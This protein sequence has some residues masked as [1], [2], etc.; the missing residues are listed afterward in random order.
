MPDTV[1]NIEL[2]AQHYA[3]DSQLV[4]TTGAGLRR[5]NQMY[6]GMTFPGWKIMGQTIIGRNFAELLTTDTSITTTAGTASYALPTTNR[7]RGRPFVE[8]LDA[9]Q[10]SDPYI[11]EYANTFTEWS[12]YWTDNTN[13]PRICMLTGGGATAGQKIEFRPSPDTT[14]DTVRIT[15]YKE[16][17]ELTNGAGTTEFTHR[18]S[19]DALAML[20]AA[21]YLAK[22]GD[23]GRAMELVSSAI[24]AMPAESVA[25]KVQGTGH[26]R[27]WGDT[28]R[29]RYGSGRRR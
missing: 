23:P 25:L 7:F 11:I 24:G 19:D 13:I 18:S 21:D 9:S 16:V 3:D 1:A 27:P 4:L 29:T 20:I 10:N 28:G 5:L 15:G 22:R 12:R 17:T 14:G 6:R 26:I 8:I 2:D